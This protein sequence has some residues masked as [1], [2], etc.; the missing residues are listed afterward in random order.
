MFVE[1]LTILLNFS[2]GFTNRPYCIF[3]NISTYFV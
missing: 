1:Q 2:E 3:E